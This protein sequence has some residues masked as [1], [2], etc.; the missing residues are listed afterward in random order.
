[1]DKKKSTELYSQIR[2]FYAHAVRIRMECIFLDGKCVLKL[3]D[4]KHLKSLMEHLLFF[5]SQC[6]FAAHFLFD[7]ETKSQRCKTKIEQNSTETQKNAGT[8]EEMESIIFSIE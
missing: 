3:F 5:T 4:S 6:T 7:M 2:S 8:Q 1:M